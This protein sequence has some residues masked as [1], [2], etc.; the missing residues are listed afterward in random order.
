MHLSKT[1]RVYALANHRRGLGA[2]DAGGRC[3]S[4]TVN[5]RNTSYG[6]TTRPGN[7]YLWLDTAHISRH[8]DDVSGA[9]SAVRADT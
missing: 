7:T 8:V 6:A 1:V 2:L 3:P 4:R 5:L 9:A